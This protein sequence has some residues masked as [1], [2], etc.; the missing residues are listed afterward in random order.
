MENRKVPKPDSEEY[1]VDNPQNLNTPKF[2]SSTERRNSPELPADEN[3]NDL[4]ENKD[5]KDPVKDEQGN[6]EL[7]NTNLGNDREEG[8]AKD[9]KI[10]DNP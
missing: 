10:I 6:Q 9:E 5:N 3:L 2:N 1:D 7:P 8:E 4:H